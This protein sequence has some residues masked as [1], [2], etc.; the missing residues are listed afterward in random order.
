[1]LENLIIIL[2]VAV[3]VCSILYYLNKAKKQGHK[4]VGCPYGK[5]CSKKCCSSKQQ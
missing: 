5:Q 2:I 4:C 1:M 3:I